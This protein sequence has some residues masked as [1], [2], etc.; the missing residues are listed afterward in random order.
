MSFRDTISAIRGKRLELARIDPRSGMPTMPPPGAS[1]A[2]IDLAERR[3]GFALPPSYRAFLE[4]HDGWP[5]FFHGAS[6]LN[7]QHLARGTYVNVARM[8]AAEHASELDSGPISVGG[9]SSRFIPFGIDTQAE[10]VIGWDPGRP[11]RAGYGELRIVMWL[12]GIGDVVESFDA[13]LEIVL[14]MLGAELEDRRSRVAAR[15]TPV[16]ASAPVRREP[17]PPISAS[18]TARVIRAA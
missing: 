2:A 11:S 17:R 8:V 14:Q 10:T 1:P 3:L 13:F 9:A 5:A 4:V 18:A 7:A 12:N 6:L 15:S 16:P